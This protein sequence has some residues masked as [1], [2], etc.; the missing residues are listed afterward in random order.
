MS[1]DAVIIETARKCRISIGTTRFLFESFDTT[2]WPLSEVPSEM[3][4][5]IE[6]TKTAVR[7][8]TLTSRNLVPLERTIQ[9]AALSQQLNV[10]PLIVGIV[11]AT[12]IYANIPLTRIQMI[13]FLSAVF[14]HCGRLINQLEP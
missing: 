14:N 7:I 9:I 13:E 11:F 12:E 1:L 6:F 4:K 3:E 10:S 5:R 2:Q 8:A